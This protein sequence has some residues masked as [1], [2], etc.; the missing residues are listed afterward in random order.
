MKT[1]T[2]REQIKKILLTTGCNDVS[3]PPRTNSGN[4]P[5]ITFELSELTHNYGKTMAQLE[6]N[7]VGKDNKSVEIDTLADEIQALLHGYSYLGEDVA[8]RLFKAGRNIVEEED[9]KIVR[10]RILFDLHI[11]E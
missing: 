8:F 9:I 1:K 6:I 11:Y 3:V 7:C 5:Y 2:L 10:R 4:Y